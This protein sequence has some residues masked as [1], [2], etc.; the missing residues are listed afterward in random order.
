MKGRS[1]LSKTRWQF[2]LCSAVGFLLAAPLFYMLTKRFY[3]EDMLDII[4]AVEHGRELPPLDL[5]RDIMA[6]MMV[7]YILIFVVVSLSLL[8]TVR[9][10]TRRLWQPFDDTLHKVEGFTPAQTELPRLAPTEIREFARLNRSLEGLMR[11]ASESVRIQKEFTENASHEL[12]TPLAA[13]R[14]CLDLLIQ[15]DLTERQ[16]QITTDLFALTGRMNRLNRNLLL[17]AG[18]ENGGYEATAEVNVADM[19]AGL[20]PQYAVFRQDVTIRVDDSSAD[21]RPMLRANAVL[22][23]CLLNNLILN[24]VRH[25]PTGGEIRIHL[26]KDALR[27][28]NDAAEARPLDATRLF[29]RFSGTASGADGHGLGLAIVQAI[30]QFHRWAVHYRFVEQKH[31]FEVSF[32]P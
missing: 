10:A 15:E 26:S 16:M 3:A 27:V 5:E 30:C 9:L 28:D 29:R 31:R 6:G 23:E 14:G 12:Q 4:E 1:L 13:M 32:R 2:V 7:Q 24:A 17:L 25:T 11:R 8:V 21:S 20:L 19:L 18:I 22:L